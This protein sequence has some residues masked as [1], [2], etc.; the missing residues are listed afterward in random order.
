MNHEKPSPLAAHEYI[1]RLHNGFVESL[2]K[3]H[4]NPGSTGDPADVSFHAYPFAAERDTHALGVGKNT[5][6]ALA[7][8]VPA[9]QQIPSGMHAL[10]R[11]VVRPDR[12]HLGHIQRFESSVEEMIRLANGVLE[13]SCGGNRLYGHSG[14][15][16][17]DAGGLRPAQ[18]ELSGG[19]YTPSRA[20]SLRVTSPPRR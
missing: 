9:E 19:D 18:S 1:R 15:E 13:T 5:L 11:V 20:I 4:R 14:V 12:F 6:P 8:L 16:S 10:Y 3:R 17:P 2:G 7:Y